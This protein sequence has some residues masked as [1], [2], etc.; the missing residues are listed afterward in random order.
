MPDISIC[1]VTFR[2]PNGL[3]R[4]LNSLK[5]IN[6][7]DGVTFEVV[8]IDNDRRESA[9]DVIKNFQKD[10]D[11]LNY[12]VEQEQNIAKARN[13]A[14][15]KARGSWIAFI[16]D[17]EVAHPNWLIRFW[18]LKGKQL[19]D[20]Y[21]GPVIPILEKTAPAW[22]D[23]ELFYGR[24][25]F[26]TGTRLNHSR[27]TRTGNTFVCKV[28]FVKYRFDLRY[29]SCG[30]SDT[31]LFSRALGDG[32]N[33]YWCDEAEVNE[34]IPAERMKFLWLAQ[35]SFR[36]GLTHTKQEREYTNNL[37]YLL[38]RFIKAIAGIVFFICGLPF[39]LIKGQQY[40]IKNILRIFVQLGHISE[41]LNIN[42][43][44]YKVKQNLNE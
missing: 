28:L 9:A 12:F 33:F 16:D 43:E 14:V 8:V 10:F 3:T 23:K 36:G 11:C 30:G 39:K 2:R 29:G 32:A 37:L 22:M 18:E 6:I 5:K 21:F 20:G 15:E 27:Q 7:T 13:L 17:D 1:V 19:G 42:Y 40:A 25:R 24:P 31:K 26:S 38:I 35:R 41:L 44:E 4:L 34:Y